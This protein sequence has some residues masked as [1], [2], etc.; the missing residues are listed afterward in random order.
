MRLS[1]GHASYGRLTQG[2]RSF[3][4]PGT[5]QFLQTVTPSDLLQLPRYHSTL[6]VFLHPIT[7]GI[8]DDLMVTSLGPEDFYVVTNAACAEKD[9]AY[10]AENLAEFRKAHGTAKDVSHVVLAGQGLLA[11]QGPEARL[12][13]QEYLVRALAGNDIVDLDKIYFGSVFS[14]CTL[15]HGDI[16]I[17]RGGYTGEDGFEISVAAGKTEAFTKM[18]LDIGRR[19][20]IVKLT[21]LGARDSLR[22]EAGMCLYGHDLGDTTTPIEAGLKWVVGKQRV[23]EGGFLGAETIIR[24][25]SD[26][27]LV[28][29][30]RVGLVVE[31]APAREGA[32]I[33]SMN[34]EQIGMLLVLLVPGCMAKCKRENHIRL[35]VSNTSQEHR[36]GIR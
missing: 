31:G 21:G 6:S 35:S 30:R 22:L 25:Y 23:L 5:L 7:G 26:L 15:E 9:A 24:Q 13:M 8:V 16:Q 4:G 33:F 28:A 29:R 10:I 20:D 34:G 12:V 19:G 18:L 3:S 14:V 11:L 1:L 36:H 17:A 32:E 2:R 27:S